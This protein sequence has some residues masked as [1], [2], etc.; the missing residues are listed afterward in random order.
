MNAAGMVG[1]ARAALLE[2]GADPDAIHLERGQL[3]TFPGN[4]VVDRAVCLAFM[5][6]GLTLTR[7]V[8]CGYRAAINHD[9][10]YPR[11]TP[12]LDVLRFGR[13]DSCGRAS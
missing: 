11:C 10:D 12:V 8:S 6:A 4:P 1:V 9:P 13:P 2:V 5:A 7:C 3:S